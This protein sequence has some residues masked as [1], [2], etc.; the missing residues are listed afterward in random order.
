MADTLLNPPLNFLAGGGEMGALTR[1]F[2]WSTTPLGLPETWPQS[3][4]T[5]VALLLTSNHPMFI[6]W[7]PELIQFYNDA[8][9]RT[10]GPERHPSA[11]G[12]RGR[13][14]WAEIWDIIGPQIEQVMTGKGATWHEDQLVPV[15][16][17]GRLE[18]V[19]WTYGY[20]PIA[21]EDGGVGGVLVV[22]NDV[23]ENHRITEEL[24][25]NQ[26]RL[27]FALDAGGGVG[28][29]DWDVPN[30]RVYADERFGVLYSV[31][32]KHAA[33]GAPI[34]EFLDA[35]YVDDREEVARA[36]QAALGS[37]GELSVEY[38]IGAGAAGTRWLL[39]R[40]RCFHD[41]RGRPL[42]FPGIVVDITERKEAMAAL[43]ASE[44]QLRLITHALPVYILRCDAEF[45][46][47]FVNTAYA[48]RF[49][50]RPE[51][52]VGKRISDIIGEA[53]WCS[54]AH[55]L[56]PLLAGEAVQYEARIPYPTIGPRFVRSVNVPERDERG[57]VRGFI[58][59]LVDITDQKQFEEE[60]ARLL[61]QSLKQAEELRAADRSKD[62]FLAMLAHEL[63]N[64]LAPINNA[65]QLLPRLIPNEPQTRQA[66]EII[67][68]QVKHMTR[69]VDDL[70]DVSR[71]TQGKVSLKKEPTDLAQA[72]HAGIELT[73]PFI[74]EKKH[75]ITITL[76]A[77]ELMVVGDPARLAQVFG[78][79]LNNA[80]KYT[81][82]HGRIAL[83][84]E[85]RAEQAI[86]QVRDSGIGIAPDLL[87]RVFDLFTQ[88]DGTLERAQGGL[89]IGL[90][91][92]RSLVALHGGSVE[93]H[94]AGQGQGSEFVVRLPVLKRSARW[95][96]PEEPDL[97]KLRP[98]RVLIV[99]DNA[100][101][102]DSMAM[103]LGLDQHEVRVVYDGNTALDAA[104]EF[105]PEVLLLDI[106]LPGI[107]GYAVARQLRAAVESKAT[108]VIAV[109]GYGQSEDRERSKAAGFDHHLVK[110][111]DPEALRRLLAQYP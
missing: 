108:L 28:I 16:R 105:E 7:G 37:A 77:E 53:A 87:P 14:C 89:G 68:R 67:Q 111:V 88:A 66:V 21:D 4:R 82:E 57:A 30:D 83:I 64:P 1:L 27:Q 29:W 63:R 106:G 40:G 75:D 44:E 79:L 103:L 109:T 50:L 70:L 3:L 5:T 49:G 20:S 48:A 10:M 74:E 60:R 104:R 35:I 52:L 45:R 8:Y 95:K 55:R 24:R 26:E 93:A 32:A 73:R 41:D 91:L 69:L 94:S 11:L 9:R 33:E 97:R 101:A 18:E 6:W 22:C 34:E 39:A 56:Q 62:E 31:D 72:L 19:W 51:E 81:E 13:D 15:T 84:A 80:A 76:P 36:I 43:R 61:E 38:R 102:A 92:V 96:P 78:N 100:D 58:G 65:A 86:I 98:R 2:D 12:Q 25:K 23:T 46:Y 42:R 99:D 85:R 17:H 110:P 90:A 59:A 107:D 71:I 54:V 47:K